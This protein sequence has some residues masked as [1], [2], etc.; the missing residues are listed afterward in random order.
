MPKDDSISQ[1]GTCGSCIISAR[2]TSMFSAM[3]STAQAP[4][5]NQW[6][7]EKCRAVDSAKNHAYR[8][9]LQSAAT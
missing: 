3:F 8:G 9:K 1:N 4:K 6:Y 7:D 5:R 2:T